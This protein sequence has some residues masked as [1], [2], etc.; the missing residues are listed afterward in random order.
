[1]YVCD[2]WAALEISFR[3]GGR[4]GQARAQGGKHMM[5]RTC[6]LTLQKTNSIQIYEIKD[7]VFEHKNK[8]LSGSVEQSLFKNEYEHL[9]AVCING[10]QSKPWA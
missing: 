5:G 10:L 9:N 3:G 4:A 8:W 1:M 7:V 6:D 2:P